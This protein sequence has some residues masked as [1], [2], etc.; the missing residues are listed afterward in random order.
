MI[1]SC[2]GY[3]YT[4]FYLLKEIAANGVK[5]VGVTNNKKYLKKTN[6]E[7]ILILPRR[8][9][10]DAIKQSTHLV[11]TAPPEKKYCPI[12]SQY[13]EN[14]KNSNI[15]SIIYISTTGVYGDHKGKWVNEKSIIKGKK[16]LYNNYRIEAEKAWRD[17]SQ[18]TITT[19][20][21]VR[22]GAIYG[23][24]KPKAD[25]S[26]F[27]DIL[28]KENHF[29]S[30]VHV[31]DI[32]RLIAK[33]LYNTTGNNYWNIVDDL[34]TTREMFVKRIIKL[35]NI[36]D[37]NFVNYAEQKKSSSTFKRKFWEAN[38]KVSNEK[39]KKKFDYIYLFPTYFSGLKHTIKHS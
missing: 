7:N 36:K 31:F 26:F 6:S 15:R 4:A 32:S 33:I 16:H 1:V 27:K 28:I 9:T 5:C 14:I 3:G 35:K 17:F 12:L 2:L 37:Y 21:I 8:M 34:P 13:R 25:K 38:K 22:L 20:N 24:G 29:F 10:I 18:N 19:L 23:P 30:R 11:V 39:I